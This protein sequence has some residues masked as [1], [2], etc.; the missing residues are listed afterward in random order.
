MESNPPRHPERACDFY[1]YNETKNVR[2]L[3]LLLLLSL[4]K[5]TA[6]Q[7]SVQQD[8]LAALLM[9]SW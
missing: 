4:L 2:L 5:S 1:V 3:L 8:A 9:C 7:G 6:R